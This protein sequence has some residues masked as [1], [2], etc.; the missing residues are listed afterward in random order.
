VTR[1]SL[2]SSSFLLLRA[3]DALVAAQQAVCHD[4][5]IMPAPDTARG[6]AVPEDAVP[7]EADAASAPALVPGRRVG[8]YRVIAQ[9]GR[10]G[11]GAVYLAERADAEFHK[12]VAIKVV[13]AGPDRDAVL[14]RFRQ[15]RQILAALDH[16]NVARLLD[17]GT[18]DDGLP[19][20][21]MEYI[22]GQPIT[23]YCDERRLGIAA[24]L[25]LFLDV[26]SAVQYAHRNLIVHRDVKP[27]NILVGADGVPRLL[28]FGIAKLLSFAGDTATQTTAALTPA[29]ASPEQVRG[30]AVTTA[31]DVYSLGV[32][33]F[34]LLT[35]RRPYRLRSRQP[36]EFMKAILEQEA[37][38]PS[39]AVRRPEVTTEPMPAAG[40]TEP[41]AEASR[42]RG[43][44]PEKLA[45]RLR[46][47]L[48][49]I[50]LLALRKEPPQRY[51]SVEAFAA[52]IRRYLEGRPVLA[53]KGTLPYRAR[54]FVSRHAWAVAAGVA[55]AGLLAGWLV[56]V[57]VQSERI[58]RERDK[59]EQIASFMRNLFFMSDP[60]QARG[61]A[62][63]ARDVLDRGAARI[64]EDRAM[65]PEVRA[66]LM[67]TLSGVYDNLGVYEPAVQLA[68]ESLEIRRG[69]HGPRHPD[70]AASLNALGNV[71]SDKGEYA[72]AEPVYREALA[73]RKALRPP[74]EGAV[75]ES[76]NNLASALQYRGAYA[77][78]EAL[79]EES[80]A[81]KRRLYGNEEKWVANTLSN[82]AIVRYYRGDYAGARERMVEALAIQRKALG[83]DHPD[84]AQTIHNV[85]VLQAEEADWTGA[86]AS[87]RDAL[88]R[89]RRIFGPEHADVAVTLHNLGNVLLR[90]GALAEAEAVYGESLAMQ[91]KLL[92]ADSADLAMNIG[93]LAAAARVSGDAAGAERRWREALAIRTKALGPAHAD[94]GATL[95]GL[96][97]AVADRGR[98][99]EAEELARRGLA[100]RRAALEARHP[101]LADGLLALANV[102]VARGAAGECET[103]AREAADIL[104]GGPEAARWRAA[105]ARSVLGACLA[106]AGRIAEAEPLLVESLHALESKVGARG[107]Q[108]VEA[109]RRLS[110]LRPQA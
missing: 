43:D 23:D 10:G 68:R 33:L 12:R 45:V 17:G 75:A 83:E 70:V 104:T 63:S 61:N 18:T 1:R 8:T 48:D 2:S 73:I 51:P 60:G 29:Y 108:A 91:R 86:E 11:M 101:D 82:I 21:V 79:F 94:I 87:Y 85:G 40:A 107:P 47:D 97:L 93:A 14:A 30:D 50:V 55:V 80:L 22:E 32:L 59:A 35:G 7:T 89:Q 6:G 58:A 19:Y 71:L 44:T 13:Q 24:R 106:A 78:C 81:I 42:A 46:G 69:L 77:E 37:E 49:N 100:V 53:R 9:L 54:K 3:R 99:P 105:E 57:K 27:G 74:D 98:L 15:E 26:C 38:R 5:T 36:V 110:A 90:R 39:T 96:A 95:A 34:E 31:S 25:R 84:V 88:A 28:D 16:P 56:S 103:L 76:L 72:A 64:R 65:P 109:S 66:E 102:L 20:F 62:L 4:P 92:G 41:L 67:H 52:D